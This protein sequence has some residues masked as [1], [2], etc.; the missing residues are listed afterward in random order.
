MNAQLKNKEHYDLM[1]Q[2]EKTYNLTPNYRESKEFWTIGYLYK[3]ASH[4]TAFIAFRHGYEFGRVV[5][6]N[7]EIKEEA[8]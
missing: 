2:F 1:A 4:N 8:K 3:N 5:F 7:A 6:R